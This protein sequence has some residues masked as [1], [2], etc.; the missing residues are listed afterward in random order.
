MSGIP[1]VDERTD[2]PPLRP[3][4]DLMDNSEGREDDLAGDRAAAE[5]HLKQIADDFDH[6]RGSNE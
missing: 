3:D 4:V 6:E 5:E 1:G 2:V